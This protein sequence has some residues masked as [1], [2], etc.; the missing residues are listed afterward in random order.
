MS[1]ICAVGGPA[2][3]LGGNLTEGLLFFILGQLMEANA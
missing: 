1:A 3:V 2:C